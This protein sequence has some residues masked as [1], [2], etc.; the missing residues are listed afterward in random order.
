EVFARH[1]TRGTWYAHASVC[2]LHVRPILDMRAGGPEGGAA[3]LRA[4]A[5]AAAALVR[6]YKGA[7]SGEHG[8]GP[9]RSERGAG[10]CGGR[11]TRSFEAI[12][13]PFAPDG[14][15]RPG[16]LVRPPRMDDASLFRY[17]PGYS[18]A[19]LATALD[20]SAWDVK[21]DPATERVTAPGTGGDPTGGLAK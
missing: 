3:E 4:I 14:L 13:D 8:D 17:K 1:G 7:V 15:L 12:K 21:N 16:K 19:P 20:W 11:L 10:R 9:V 5:E 18:V 2:T 6:R